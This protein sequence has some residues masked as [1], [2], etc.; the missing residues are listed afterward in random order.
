MG[1][2]EKLFRTEILFDTVGKRLQPSWS[3]GWCL[4]IERILENAPRELRDAALIELIAFEVHVRQA[5]GDDPVPIEYHLR[6]PHDSDKVKTALTLSLKKDIGRF[7]LLE[8]IDSGGFGTVYRA[9]DPVLKRQVA[10]KIPRQ[11]RLDRGEVEALLGEA[12]AAARLKHPGIVQVYDAGMEGEWAYIASEFI[13]GASLRTHLLAPEPVSFRQVAGICQQVAEALQHAHELGIIHQD[14]KPSNILLDAEGR[15]YLT[16]FGLARNAAEETQAEETQQADRGVA[17]TL[18]YMSPE[19]VR[20]G[21]SVTAASDI[22][23]LGVVLYEMLTGSCPFT[24]TRAEL[25]RQIQEAPVPRL[26][27]RNPRIPRDLEAICLKCLAREP[28]N[29]YPSAAELADDLRRYLANESVRARPGIWAERAWRWSRRK[30]ALAAALSLLTL[31]M[32]AAAVLVGI[33]H[34]QAWESLQKA[35]TNLYFYQIADAHQKW[36]L[37]SPEDARESLAACPNWRRDFEWWHLDGLFRTPRR[38]LSVAGK[39][40]AF[41]SDGE[42]IVTAG[43]GQPGVKIWEGKTGNGLLHMRPPNGSEDW[44]QSVDYAPDGRTVASGSAI[45]GVVRLWDA[46]NGRFL[47]ELGPH[48]RDVMAVQF[49]GDGRRIVSLGRNESLVVWETATGRELQRIELRPKS[50]QA[51][52][53]SPVESLVVVS[54]RHRNKNE[55]AVWDYETGEQVADLSDD[56]SHATGLAFS[57]DGC[58]LAVAQPRGVLQIWEF[59]P[60]RLLETIPGPLAEKACPVFAPD[61]QRIAAEVWDGAICIWDALTGMPLGVFR[62]HVAPVN[63]IRFSPDGRYLV[64]GS[65]DHEIRFWDTQTEQGTVALPGDGAVALDLAVSPQG[66]SL[67]VVC[68]D[69]SAVLWN[70]A[71]GQRRWSLPPVFSAPPAL[72]AV[73][74]SPDGRH[75][76]CAGE[77]ATVRIY[78]VQAGTVQRCF[79]AHQVA[80]RAVAYSP[81]GKRLASAGL[82]NEVLIWDADSG[83][84]LKKLLVDTRAIRC[85]KFHPDGTRL[86]VGT[87]DGHALVWDLA[88]GQLLWSRSPG[89]PLPRVWDLA[90]SPDGSCLAVARGD[91][92]VRL[93]ESTTGRQLAEFGL[94]IS[95]VPIDLAFSP[96]GCRLATATEQ[97]GV[98]LWEV[99]TGRKILTISRGVATAAAV[100]FDPTGQILASADRDGTVKLWHGTRALEWRK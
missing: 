93:H 40:F 62:G 47:R 64:A 97:T 84:V 53:I 52:A 50:V 67:A 78:D 7:K 77:D 87:R 89:V 11:E 56:A 58:L 15:P 1:K 72:W 8:Q 32:I 37:N 4:P 36:L 29:R 39:A 83:Q 92:F 91:G 74:Y 34:W 45:D 21:Q 94:P 6:F 69:G 70:V 48:R 85:L 28:A 26:R 31:V 60:L 30:P 20:G 25:V 17:G 23:S 38:R 55:I 90:W 49:V 41:R 19:Q 51:L 75:L 14:V 16:D 59:S 79:T 71:T 100:V 3:R 42:R 99:P 82:G 76:A 12:R 35:E 10:L 81:D 88:S 27:Q 73:A 86:A 2:S 65:E 98:I 43:G 95:N 33:S 5:V 18:P 68:R 13:E 63:Q 46:N 54:T 22:Y 9:H 44:I 66:D 57:P 96:N 24:G 61:G 80:L